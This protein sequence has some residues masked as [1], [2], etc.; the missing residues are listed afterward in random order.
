MNDDNGSISFLLLAFLSNKP[1]REQNFSSHV[2][3]TTGTEPF[4][5]KALESKLSLIGLNRLIYN[6]AQQ[7]VNFT[8]VKIKLS[9]IGD[10]LPLNHADYR[11]AK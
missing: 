6:Q 11:T 8:P 7:C 2:F 10:R 1:N 4:D 5:S 3:A 9:I